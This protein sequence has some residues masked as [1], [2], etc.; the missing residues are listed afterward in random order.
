MVLD[1]IRKGIY[2]GLGVLVVTGEEIRTTVDRLV[3][4]GKLSAED[5]EALIRD[6]TAKGEKQQQEF[7][8]WL[9]ETIRG[10]LDRLNLPGRQQVEDLTARVSNLEDRVALLEDLRRRETR[11]PEDEG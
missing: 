8:N 11:P 10:A 4:A 2:A 5:S 3:A 7:Q 9:S 6:L 1:F